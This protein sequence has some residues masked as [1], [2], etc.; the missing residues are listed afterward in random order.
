MNNNAEKYQ[1]LS[2]KCGKDWENVKYCLQT[3][4]DAYV[5]WGSEH[6]LVLNASKSKAMLVC[7]SR[8]RTVIGS[9]APFNAGNRQIMFVRSYC[10]LGCLVNDELTVLNEYKAVYRKAER[11]VYM[12]G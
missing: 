6:N 5:K 3:D 8:D 9:P 12:L 11:K 7:N 4:L 10:Y 1:Y 2:S